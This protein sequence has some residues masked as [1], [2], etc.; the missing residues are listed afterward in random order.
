MKL[1]PVRRDTFFCQFDFL[2]SEIAR[3]HELETQYEEA[4]KSHERE[5]VHESISNMAAVI[6]TDLVNLFNSIDGLDFNDERVSLVI[7]MLKSHRLRPL[8][9][10]RIPKMP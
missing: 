4:E 2:Q 10:K 1:E 6:R 8:K 9:P 7:G 3:L 5:R